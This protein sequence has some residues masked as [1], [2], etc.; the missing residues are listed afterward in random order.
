MHKLFAVIRREFMVRVHTRAFVISTILGPVLM[1]FLFVF[2]MLLESRDR[3][4]K[5]V[6]VLDAASG[7]FGVR[8]T[9]ALAAARRGDGPDAAPRYE[10]LRVQ[11]G[12]G[13]L[14]PLDSLIALTG[15]KREVPGAIV[16][17]VLVT[18]SV[19]DTGRLHYFG[20]NV[21]S[22]SEMGDL[23]RTIRQV[24]IAERLGREGV[25]PSVLARATAPVSLETSRVSN[26]QL[27]GES[28]ESSFILA[29]VMSFLL[30]IALLLYGTQVMG[31]VVEEKSN[32]IMEVLVS[33]LSPFE[34][35]FGKVVGVGS[36]A[37]LQLGIWTGSAKLLTSQRAAIAGLFGASPSE[38]VSMPIPAISGTLLAVY[39]T[40]FVLGFFLYSAAYAAV[41]A[42]VST[43]QEAQQAAM[44]VSLC[45]VAGLMLMFGLLDEPNGTLAR[46]MSMIPLFAPFVTPV[47]Y[48]LSPL[49]LS[50][51]LASAGVTALG[52]VAVAWVAGRI[53]RV[54]ILMYGKRASIAEIFRWIRT[55]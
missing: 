18:D 19:I 1:G 15:A 35:M 51:V 10:V 47:R 48:S 33:S 50:E 26:G 3:A 22:L 11:S 6:V 53:Y 45:I 9:D 25:D 37:L 46:T 12:V 13:N 39:L 14:G 8:V 41:A 54:G 55:G 16:G 27:S 28:G 7:E 21:G 5:R 38:A 30:Y 49:P 23:Q 20:S 40:F 52:V 42:T 31:S 32:R 24:V 36:V 2:P 4:P 29:Y 17:L 43:Q 44:P 34:L